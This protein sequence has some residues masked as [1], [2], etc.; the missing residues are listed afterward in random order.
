MGIFSFFSY[1]NE[2]FSSLWKLIQLQN[3]LFI[4]F[5]KVSR[6]DDCHVVCDIV[7]EDWMEGD[8]Q[9]RPRHHD[10]GVD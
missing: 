8:M 4:R 10:E 9:K 5:S 1:R 2:R 3:V 6:F 7:Q